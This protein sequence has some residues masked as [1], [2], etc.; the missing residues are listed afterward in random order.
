MIQTN[1]VYDKKWLIW[2][3]IGLV[4]MCGAMKATGG[5]G[6][7]L[8]VPLILA[9]FGKNRPELMLY[10]LLM[11][12]MLTVTNDFFAP[13]GMLFSVAA[14]LVYIVVGAV[15]TLQI[16]G[17]RNSRL[18][19]P[20]LSIL[21]YIVYMALV[22]SVGWQPIISYLKMVLFLIVFLALYSVANI[23]ALRGGTRAECL[24]SVLL[25]FAVFVIFGSLALIPFPGIGKMGAERAVKEG[26]SVEAFG[27]FQGVTFHS[28]TLGPLVAGVAN[29][30]FADLLFSVRRMNKL[31]VALL[32]GGA[33]L[34]YYSTSRTA[35]GTFLSGI[36]FTGFVFMNTSA[37]KVGGGRWKQRALATLILVGIL[38]AIGLFASPGVREKAMSFIFKT[39]EEAVAEEYVSFDSLVSSR[40]GLIDNAVDNFKES[41]WIGNGFQVSRMQ[42][43]MNIVSWKQLLTAPIEKGV[44]L[45]AVPEE[46]G[47]FG[48]AIFIIFILVSFTALISRQAY[49]GASVLFVFLVSNLGEFTFF[50]M[51]ANGGILWALVFAG[52]ALDAQRLRQ[53][54]TPCPWLVANTGRLLSHDGE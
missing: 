46:G 52:V 20:L 45:Y 16:V 5:V 25:C 51:S 14:R 8:I 37:R 1:A 36:L 12:A 11:T 6:F 7:L 30:L 27:L 10:C 23:T 28:Q 49:I 21:I 41:P 13:K 44:W 17:Q 29:I 24:R 38:G 53:Q 43:D 54:A 15:L 50:S 33:I 39:G 35:M 40:Q 22:S 34:I 31:Y 48:M 18:M 3:L 32:C 2:C 42:A 9:A 19:T 26:L 4:V 47:I